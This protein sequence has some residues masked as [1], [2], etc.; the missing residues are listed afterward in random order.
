MVLYRGLE[1]IIF[2]LLNTERVHQINVGQENLKP[3]PL[4]EF[5]DNAEIARSEPLLYTGAYVMC[6]ALKLDVIS[7]CT[8][9]PTHITLENGFYA[10][11]LCSSV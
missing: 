1:Q 4:Q 11:V 5:N 8:R 9:E 7:L 3:H 10:G 6:S 2:E